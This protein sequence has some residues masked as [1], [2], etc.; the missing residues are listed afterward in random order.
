MGEQP[1]KVLGWCADRSRIH[2][3][4]RETGQIAAI[5]PAAQAA[6]L[7]TLAPLDYWETVTPAVRT[8]ANWPAALNLV[9][10]QANKAGVFS[11]DRLRGRGVWMDGTKVVWHL[12]DRLEVDGQEVELIEHRSTHHYPRLPALDVDPASAPLSD[13]Q[14][15]EILAAVAAMGWA[16]PLDHLHLV[17]WI[18]L[19]SVCGALDKR[20]VLQITC[21][22]GKG[23]T[24][25][26]TGVVAPLLAGLAISQSNSTEAAVRQTLNTDA[27]PVLL[28]ESEGEDHQRREGHLKL[29]RLSFDGTETSRGTTHGKALSYAVRSSVAL[30][31]INAMIVNPAE[32]SRTVVVGRQ[33]LPQDQWAK[34]DRTLRQLLTVEV[35]AQLLRRAVNHLHT[36]RANVA[37][38][39]RIVEGQLPAGA[40]ARA[41]D[42]YGALLAGAHLLTSTKVVDDVQA[43]AWLD[44]MNWSAP[45]ALGVE[46]AD[47]QSAAAEGVQC[48]AKL[49]SHE[50]QWRN[51]E[52][53][54]ETGRISIRELIELAR[55]NSSAAEAAEARKVL[56]R[57]GIKATDHGLVIANSAETLAPIY[58]NTKWR[59]GG[60][61]ERL[62]ELPGA[63]AAGPKHFT[64]GG[65]HK[66]TTI[67]WNVAGF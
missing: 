59:G 27:L 64:G 47:G 1:F 34:V 48:L 30:V 66:A 44:L 12:G 63:E 10:E 19:A 52:A 11:L 41:G 8:G 33:P 35:G 54:Y 17:G 2:Y 57:R 58:G 36:M 29:A 55:I 7:L 22:Y 38:F 14:G 16:T 23:K 61:R 5:K 4:H 62:R 28:D 67:P 25:T 42:T 53:D 32:R 65:T 6:T 21:G 31:G 18:V 26:L 60:H 9:V 50:E 24:Y 40:A 37:T 45:A 51:K 15:G 46:V 49:F 39:R 43:V 13:A 3:Q 56:G 20:P